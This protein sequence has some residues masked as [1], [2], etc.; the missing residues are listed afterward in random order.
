[1]KLTAEQQQRQIMWSRLM[2]PANDATMSQPKKKNRP[3][4]GRNERGPFCYLT[5]EQLAKLVDFLV[6]LRSLPTKG[7]RREYYEI[8]KKAGYLLDKNG[9]EQTFGGFRQY[10]AIA[11]TKRT[12]NGDIQ[13]VVRHA[14]TYG[15]AAELCAAIAGTDVKEASRIIKEHIEG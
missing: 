5:C 10:Y 6:S 11:M 8:A 14:R 4:I 3:S 1:M 15:L 9:N 12:T 13:A 2:V 7:K